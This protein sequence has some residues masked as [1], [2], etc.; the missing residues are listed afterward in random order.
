M[1]DTFGKKYQGVTHSNPI[2]TSRIDAQKS[3]RSSDLSRFPNESYVP[4]N[5]K[6]SSWRI[7]QR[8]QFTDSQTIK[9][10]TNQK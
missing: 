3:V 4:K 1:V 10:R 9:V 8:G 2:T 7:L 5:E 6:S